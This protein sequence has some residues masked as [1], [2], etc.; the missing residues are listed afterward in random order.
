MIEWCSLL[1]EQA[2]MSREREA[3]VLPLSLHLL[4]SYLPMY[5]CNCTL[6]TF[7][8]QIKSFLRFCLAFVFGFQTYYLIDFSKIYRLKG[9]EPKNKGHTN[10]Y[11]CCDLTKKCGM[12]YHTTKMECLIMPSW[13]RA[14]IPKWKQSFYFCKLL[15]EFRM[16]VYARASRRRLRCI[17]N[18]QKASWKWCSN[19][20][21]T[22]QKKTVFGQL[23]N[24]EKCFKIC[25]VYGKRK[26]M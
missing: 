9:L 18:S 15:P 8:C 24:Q 17:S 7:F 22:L 11:E 25:Y 3:Q 4:S 14:H 16:L 23:K 13:K 12:G 20:S 19:W 2:R 5:V 6:D 1:D 21:N 26:P 10:C